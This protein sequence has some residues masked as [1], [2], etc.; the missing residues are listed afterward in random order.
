MDSLLMMRR[1]YD[2]CA[3]IFRGFISG[4]VATALPDGIE[5][6]SKSPR[7]SLDTGDR[8]DYIAAVIS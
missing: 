1:H 7:L 5:L 6:P 3:P 4:H 8:S 2:A